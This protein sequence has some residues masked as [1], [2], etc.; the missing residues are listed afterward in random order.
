MSIARVTHYKRMATLII[1]LLAGGVMATESITPTTAPGLLMKGS[2]Q[3]ILSVCLLAVTTAL[4]ITSRMLVGAYQDRISALEASVALAA[5][6]AAAETTLAQALDRMREHCAS[7]AS[8][9]HGG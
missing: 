6:K 7:A 8:A 4:C 1:I 3:I 2:A 9:R 5:T